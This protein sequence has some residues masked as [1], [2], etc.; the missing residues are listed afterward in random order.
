MHSAPVE[1]NSAEKQM[2]WRERQIM[3]TKNTVAY[4]QYALGGDLGKDSPATPNARDISMSKRRFEGRL[5]V[6]RD[7]IQSLA[8]S[9][10][11][12]C[13]VYAFLMEGEPNPFDD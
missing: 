5:R 4:R 9:E 10:I 1:T 13:P 3:I 12:D 2:L 7:Y 11:Q 8:P 6:W